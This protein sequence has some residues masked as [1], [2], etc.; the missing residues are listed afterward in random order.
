MAEKFVILLTQ[1]PNCGGIYHS[2]RTKREHKI[3][4]EF[5]DYRKIEIAEKLGRNFLTQ[6][7]KIYKL[8]I[9]ESEKKGKTLKIKVKINRKSPKTSEKTTVCNNVYK[10]LLNLVL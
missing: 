7:R 6:K 10:K 1:K 4:W 3:G 9:I 2:S 8:G 5:R